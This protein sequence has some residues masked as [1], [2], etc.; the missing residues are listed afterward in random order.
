MYVIE[1]LGASARKRPAQSGARHS[2][3]SSVFDF[4]DDRVGVGVEMCS[5]D[6]WKARAYCARVR[7]TSSFKG[8]QLLRHSG[9]STF[10]G[11]LE[12]GQPRFVLQGLFPSG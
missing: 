1:L 10:L 3:K 2:D 5:T 11:T 8:R 12:D 6:S 7:Q 4:N 9:L